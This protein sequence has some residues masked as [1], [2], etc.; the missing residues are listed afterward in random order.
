VWAGNPK[1]GYRD[2]LLRQVGSLTGK[3]HFYDITN[4]RTVFRISGILQISQPAKIK[5]AG[6]FLTLPI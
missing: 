6:P 2:T 4:F 3:G 1:K 5:I